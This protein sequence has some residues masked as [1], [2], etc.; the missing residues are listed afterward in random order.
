MSLNT[1][2]AP[3]RERERPALRLLVFPSPSSTLLQHFEAFSVA[4]LYRRHLH[5]HSR[6]RSPSLGSPLRLLRPESH[7]PCVSPPRHSWFDRSGIQQSF[8]RAHRY[9]GTAGDWEVRLSALETS[10]SKVRLRL[11]VF[12]SSSSQQLGSH[13]SRRRDHR[14]HLQP[15]GE[16]K[17]NGDVLSR[18]RVCVCSPV[19][20]LVYERVD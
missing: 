16:G 17:C 7:L 12:P 18:N 11:N 20:A 19:L 10:V 1:V 5:R 6:R 9:T 2:P 8:G 13:L 14:R 4:R 15:S 3:S